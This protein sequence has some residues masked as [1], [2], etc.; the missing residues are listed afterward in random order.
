MVER[1]RALW[2]DEESTYNTDPSADGSGYQH[3]P[4]QSLPTAENAQEGVDLQYATGRNHGPERIPLADRGAVNGI[5]IPLLG[6]GTSSG[7]EAAPPATDMVDWIMTSALGQPLAAYE[8]EGVAA[9]SGASNVI[10]DDTVTGLAQYI[11]IPVWYATNRVRWRAINSAAG[12]PTYTVLPDWDSLPLDSSIMYG[13]RVWGQQ[14]QFQTQGATLHTVVQTNLRNQRLGG[15]RPTALSAHMTAGGECVLRTSFV[16]DSWADND[17]AKSS[18]PA[19]TTIPVPAIG[20]LSSVYWGSTALTVSQ[21]DIDFGLSAGVIPG[22]NAANG[23]ADHVINSADPTI[24]I[25]LAW[26]PASYDV[27]FRAGT[28]RSLL[29]QMGGGTSASRVNSFCFFAPRVEISQPP[30]VGGLNGRLR[31]TVTFRVADSG[32]SGARRWCWARV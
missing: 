24:T 31:H 19:P 10:L 21:V 4:L 5:E 9:G 23:R 12:A 25:N 2:V 17:T 3:V 16:S 30:Q 15:V 1:V 29:V 11:P 7:D 18:L 27:D 14:D 8:G 22:A 6:F 28:F 20:V 13:A 32:V 26:D